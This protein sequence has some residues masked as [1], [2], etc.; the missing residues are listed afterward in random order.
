MK[1]VRVPKEKAEEVRKYAEKIGAKDKTRLIVRKGEFVEIPIYDDFIDH[2]K[3]YEII[4][5]KNPVFSRPKNITDAL[6][7]IIPHD[8]LRFAPKRYKIIGDII[9][10]KIHE[11]LE[12][13]KFKIGEALL[14]LHPHCKS[15]WRD[16]GKEGMIR[17]PKV[18]CIAGSGSETIHRENKCLFKLDVTKV[19]YSLGNQAERAR[20]ARIVKDGEVVVD[21]FAGIG[22]FSIPIAVH[23]NA[24]KIYSIEINPDAF[25][26]LIENIKINC[27][28]N[29]VPILGDCMFAAPEGV[30]DRVI[31]GHIRCHDFIKKAMTVLDKEGVIHYHESVPEPV[32]ERPIIRLKKNAE[33][34][35]KNIKILSYRKVKNYSPGVYH[36]V[37]D[38]YV[39][40]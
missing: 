35:N 21:M 29:I 20:M 19:M 22:Y 37:V 11:K 9:I 10:I 24:E 5:Q 38:A 3:E 1:A 36:V 31:M 8:L 17:K 26:Y 14:D 23:S 6:K 32:M 25:D 40:T 27:V 39:Y 33:L 34:L 28:D 30:A 16:F 18:E 2:F 13:Y 7:R 15:V 12:K 4:E